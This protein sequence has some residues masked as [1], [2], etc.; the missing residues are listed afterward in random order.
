MRRITAWIT[1]ERVVPILKG[2]GQYEGILG[3]DGPA[4][5]KSD[6]ARLETFT[7]T[8]MNEIFAA[9]DVFTM[10]D[11]WTGNVIVRVNEETREVERAYVVDWEVTKPG[12]P[13]LDFGQLAAELYT[14]GCFH[15]NRRQEVDEGL[16]AYGRAYAS[17]RKVD[18]EF[19]RGAGS[20]VGAH[21]VAITSTVSGWGT[22]ER[23]REVV[24]EG[25]MYLLKGID[26]DREWLR[27][28]IVAGLID[29]NVS[30]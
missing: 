28:S 24:R 17:I 5:A 25:T 20:H 19:V 9:K 1:Y 27:S 10:G 12:I 4:L 21:L 30:N 7:Q 29:I 11:F 18:E 2:E 3:S 23:V 22:K 26:G 6:L 8:R 16:R 14:I 13:F 15:E